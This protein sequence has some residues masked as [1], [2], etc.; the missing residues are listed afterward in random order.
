MGGDTLREKAKNHFDFFF[1]KWTKTGNDDFL[2]CIA[3]MVDG[4][5]SEVDHK[6]K[7]LDPKLGYRIKSED[8]PG[9]FLN[10]YLNESP[11]QDSG[12]MLF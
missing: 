12:S 5:T 9:H 7:S 11:Y 10:W 8:A 3:G 4:L 2:H 1:L 6:S